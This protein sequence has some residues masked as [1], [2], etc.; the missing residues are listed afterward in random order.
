M[1]RDHLIIFSD[2]L[3]P[4]S[5]LSWSIFGLKPWTSIYHFPTFMALLL[6]GSLSGRHYSHYSCLTDIIVTT[7]VSS[8][9]PHFGWGFDYLLRSSEDLGACSLKGLR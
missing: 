4:P 2:F 6:I 9:C 5:M 7:L 1:A 8:T 3:R